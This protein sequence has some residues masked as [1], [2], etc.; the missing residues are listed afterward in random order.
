M[1]IIDGDQQ[2]PAHRQI[3]H[4][5]VQAVQHRERT[6]TRRLGGGLATKQRPCRCG[7]SS[8]QRLTLTGRSARQA[9]LEQLAYHPERETR[10]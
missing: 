3:G 8:Q 9:P 6:V 2:R 1:R 5:P 7:R 4:Q 10:L